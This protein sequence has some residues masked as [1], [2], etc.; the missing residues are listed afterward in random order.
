[1]ENEK[2]KVGNSLNRL[3]KDL[4]DVM[5]NSLASDGIFY[6]HSETNMYT[7]YAIIIGPE[8]TPY[9][10]GIYLFEFTFPID[11]P[12]SPPKV[13]YYTN[14]GIT[15]FNPNF[16]KNGKVC[17]SILNTWK[18]EQWTSCQTI[19]SVLLTL[20][21]VLNN[22]PL[23]NEPGYSESHELCKPYNESVEFMNYKTAIF[24][25]ITKKSLPLQFYGFYSI[26]KN[27]FDKNKKKILDNIDNLSNS[28]NDNRIISIRFY[29]METHINY[30]K[31]KEHINK[32]L[33]NSY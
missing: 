12:F 5:K 18:G 14:N 8:N 27:H 13:T 7:G 2:Q 24:D 3:L 29:N 20:V 25:M 10:N 17:L 31:L 19:R 23:A 4:K 21:T 28:N 30:T 22:N 26:I 16:Y 11:Y 32:F 1:M 9:E 33:I 15:R 6:N